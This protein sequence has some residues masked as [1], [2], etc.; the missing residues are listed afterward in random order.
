M[1][2]VLLEHVRDTFLQWC[3][4]H[5]LPFTESAGNDLLEGS[6]IYAPDGL[7]SVQIIEQKETPNDKGGIDTET[8]FRYTWP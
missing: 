7:N 3:Q 4:R 1:K 6:Q 8:I 5:D 2:Y